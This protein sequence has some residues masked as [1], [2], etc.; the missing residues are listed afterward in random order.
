[1]RLQGLKLKGDG[2]C[3]STILRGPSVFHREIK[4]SYWWTEYVDIDRVK[5]SK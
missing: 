4:T 1:M 2:L 3:I 5:M